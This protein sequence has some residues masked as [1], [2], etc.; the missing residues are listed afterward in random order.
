MWFHHA[1]PK[2]AFMSWLSVKNR[3]STLDRVAR[4]S[5]GIDTTCVLC[6]NA[7]ETRDHLFFGCNFSAQIWEHLTKG[8]L[9]CSFTTDWTEIL[10]I[11]SDGKWE[12]KSLFCVR[13][14]FQMVLYVVWRERNM[15]RHGEKG[16]PLQVIKEM[17]D[18]GMRTKITFMRRGGVKGMESLMQY[19]FQTRL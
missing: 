10:A 13:Y 15:I 5:Q 8:I 3:M 2:Y 6:K 14:A 1:T 12:K 18:K 4:W 16:M 11:I 17:V 19:W 9:C 7:P